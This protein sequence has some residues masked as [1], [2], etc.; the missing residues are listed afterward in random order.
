MSKSLAI[1]LFCSEPGDVDRRSFPLTAGLPFARG[2][3]PPGEPV[4]LEDAAGNHLSL[5][6]P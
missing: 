4:A 6:T 1:D 2:L 3:L 5:Q